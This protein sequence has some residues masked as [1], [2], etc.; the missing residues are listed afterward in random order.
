MGEDDRDLAAR[1]RA[2]QRWAPGGAMDGVALEDFALDTLVGTVERCLERLAA[3]AQG[4]VEE[5]IVCPANVP[6]S[7]FDWGQV[8]LIAERL[9]PAAREI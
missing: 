4:G 6:F 1:Y 3:F 9:I 8:E 2:L 7:V 5:M